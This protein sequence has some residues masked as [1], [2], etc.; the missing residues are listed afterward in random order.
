M[1]PL[2]FAHGTTLRELLADLEFD[3]VGTSYDVAVS[4]RFGESGVEVTDAPYAVGEVSFHSSLCF[5][6]AGPNRTTQPRRALA[7]TY[8]ADGA[9]VV[10]APT[11]VS[12]TW[13]E[14]LPD[15]AAGRGRAQSSLNPGGRDSMISLSRASVAGMPVQR[16]LASLVE[17]LRRPR[18]RTSRRTCPWSP[19]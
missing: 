15:T 14:F 16:L 3:K 1:G 9:R 17:H 11:M 13:Q 12:G 10:D 8:F 2:S 7:T 5:H 6:T 4:Q 18:R 19:G